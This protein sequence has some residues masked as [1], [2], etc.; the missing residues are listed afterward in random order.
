GRSP[1]STRS[2]G[3]SIRDPGY[4]PIRRSAPPAAVLPSFLM[5][6][7]GVIRRGAGRY[8]PAAL[9]AALAAC[10]Q[11]G[12]GATGDG[13]PGGAADAGAGGIG[14]SCATG[15]DCASGLCLA[16]AAGS[17]CTEACR[18]G[19][20]PGGWSCA[21][22][23]GIEQD[24]LVSQVCVPDGP[25]CSTCEDDSACELAGGDACLGAGDGP[26]TCA[27]NCSRVGC[28]AG[29]T[30]TAMEV[31]GQSTR[32]CLPDSGACECQAG[33][34]GEE[35]CV[36]QTQLG[37]CPGVRTCLGA[38]GWSECAPLDDE[39]PPDPS[40]ID[41]NC[42]GIDG[43]LADAIAVATGGLDHDGCGLGLDTP[44]RTVERGIARAAELGRSQ[45]LVQAGVYDGPIALRS[46][47]RRVGKE[48][49]T[50]R[51]PSQCIREM[52]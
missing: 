27:R 26:G 48:R 5:G 47:E 15:E 52:S 31:G 28:P 21:G 3:A 14:D 44:C 42:D 43:V 49:T 8:L 38:G 51:S 30:C 20:C 39:D 4:A 35:A 6:V 11:G 13:G 12:A 33:D 25:L 36:I 32:Q 45:V 41:D 18:D 46:E 2:A 22:V 37:A 1:R 34:T 50:R 10:A 19:D 29:F 24:G 23:T 7:C 9:L 16:L 17:V 40:F